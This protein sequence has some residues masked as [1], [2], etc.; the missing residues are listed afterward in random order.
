MG[1]LVACGGDDGETSPPVDDATV[2]AGVDV[3]I[4]AEDDGSGESDVDEDAGPAVPNICAEIGAEPREWQEGPYG[5]LRRDRADDFTIE[6]VDGRMWSYRETF[7][8]CDSIIVVT[9][10]RPVSQSDRTSLWTQDLDELLE[11]SPRNVH[12]IFVSTASIASASTNAMEENVGQTLSRLSD[13]D[14]A[15]WQN[16]LHVAK[17]GASSLGNWVGDVVQTPVGGGGIGV[18]RFQRVRGLGSFADVNRVNPNAEGWPYDGNIALAAS[19]AVYF[20]YEAER[21]VAMNAHEVTEVVFWDGDVLAEFED[22]TV[23]LPSADEMATF[24]TMEIWLEA[25]CPDENS[26]EFGN[27]GAWD[28]LAHLWLLVGEGEEEQRVEMGRFITTYHRAGAYLVDVTPMMAHLLAGGEHR[29]RWE[30]APSWNTQ[31]TATTLSLR[32]SNQGRGERP[33]ALIPLYEGGAFNS[34][35]NNIHP[36][37]DVQIP[38]GADRTELYAVI[39]GHGGDTQNCAEFCNHQHQFYINNESFYREHTDVGVQEG[40]SSRIN[41]GVV[42]NQSG[43]WW[44][45]RGG[46]CPGQQVEPDVFDVTEFATPGE[47]IGVEYY[48]TLAGQD[49]PDNAGNI[50]M[51]SYLVV[52][53]T[54]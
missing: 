31:P 33:T 37:M 10:D 11:R 46:W 52:Y 7:T 36:P 30:F 9:D 42:P 45:G 4:D 34:E 1:A 35:Y 50:I 17:D 54:M 48:G 22:T 20:D 21:D 49:P 32:F 3:E 23:T 27:C 6:T 51:F 44:F 43:T 14:R 38:A 29:F 2:D 13:S 12:Y 28:Y 25:F 16:R 53:E 47:S 39:T 18:D 24:D 15:H 26:A 8:G 19:E 5:A 40:C 41:E